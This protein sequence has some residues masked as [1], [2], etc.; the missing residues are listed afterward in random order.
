MT[1]SEART[2]IIKASLVSFG[3]VFVFFVVAPAIGYPLRYSDAINVM[4]ILIP[5]FSSYLGAA[6]SYVISGSSNTDD[7]TSIAILRLLVVWPII[8]F[9]ICM[10]AILVAFPISQ[11][12]EFSGNGMTPNTLSLLVSLLSAVLATTTG[13][14]NSYLFVIKK[15]RRQVGKSKR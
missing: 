3:C 11:N 13:A 6:A 1:P 2:W 12:G 10:I 14:I 9:A 15:P 5:I 7:E 8:L 4:K